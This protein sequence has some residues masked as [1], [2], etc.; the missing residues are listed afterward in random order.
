MAHEIFRK[1]MV[2]LRRLLHTMPHGSKEEAK[3]KEKIN[4]KKT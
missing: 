4:G 1:C 3:E 2:K